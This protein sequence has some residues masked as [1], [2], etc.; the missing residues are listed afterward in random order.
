MTILAIR[1]NNPGDVS[2]PIKGWT[3]GGRIVGAPGQVGYAEFPTM[4]IGYQAFLFRLREYIESG[5]NTIRKIG[6][7]YATDPHWP[8]AVAKLSKLPIGAF[9]DT[10]DDKEMEALAAAILLQETGMT[11][12][13]LEAKSQLNR[14]A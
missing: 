7:V 9:L 6:A 11:I 2:L 8:V 14:K 12:A 5:R 1:Y 3:G 10:R 13:E 4:A